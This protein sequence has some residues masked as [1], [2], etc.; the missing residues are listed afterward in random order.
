MTVNYVFLKVTITCSSCDT[1]IHLRSSALYCV[2]FLSFVLTSA[3]LFRLLSCLIID[4]RL[5]FETLASSDGGQ[6]N[7]I[8]LFTLCRSLGKAR[9]QHIEKNDTQK[10]DEFQFHVPSDFQTS[11]G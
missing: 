7:L 1:D 8:L 4:H 10:I 5:W 9:I 3:L 6:H 11:K 2:P